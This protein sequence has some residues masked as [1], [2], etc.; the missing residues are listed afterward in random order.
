[1]HRFD[2]RTWD[3]QVLGSR[4]PVAVVFWAEWCL[5][6]RTAAQQMETL[7][8][9]RPSGFRLGT[10]NVDENPRTTERYGIQGLPTLLVFRGAH[11]SERRVGLMSADDI[12]RLLDR[13]E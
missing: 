12:G 7:A 8:A 3:A 1:V 11:P 4:E 2:D 13:H 9:G 5:P 6:S 10:I